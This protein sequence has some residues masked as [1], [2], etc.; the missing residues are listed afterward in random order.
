MQESETVT[1]TDSLTRDLQ[2]GPAIL[3]LGQSYFSVAGEED[4]FLASIASRTERPD[5]PYA[6]LRSG[7]LSHSREEALNWLAERARLAGVADWLR[8]IEPFPWSAVYSSSI[9]PNW[10]RAFRNFWRETEPVL[11]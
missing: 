11:S 2:R 8:R 5:D 3:L 4:A 6:G 10:E 7:A 1:A 9:E